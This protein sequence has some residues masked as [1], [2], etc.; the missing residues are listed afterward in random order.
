MKN[1]I[2]NKWA[3][4][5]LTFSGLAALPLTLSAAITENTGTNITINAGSGTAKNSV[6][7]NNN[8]VAA[9]RPIYVSGSGWFTGTDITVSGTAATG[10]GRNG[11][12]IETGGTVSLTDSA[13]TT[14]LYGVTASGTS[15]AILN[16]V[17]VST[18]VTSGHGINLATSSALTMIGGAITT[19]ATG[20]TGINLS[21]ASIGTLSNVNITTQNGTGIN[22]NTSA[23][24]TVTSCTLTSIASVGMLLSNASSLI[25]T[26]LTIRSYSRGLTARS[27]ATA[28]LTGVNILTESINGWA[29][30]S[31]NTGVITVSGGTI[32][33][34][35]VDGRGLAAAGGGTIYASDLV[36]ETIGN[37]ANGLDLGYDYALPG[38]RI[39]GD[40]LTVT[41]S[42]ADAH[43]VNFTTSGTVELMNSSLIV[44]GE[45]N[46]GVNMG[47]VNSNT[48]DYR[49]E[50]H[51]GSVES[52]QGGGIAI[53]VFLPR[54]DGV[55]GAAADIAAGGIYEVL[56]DSGA[57]VTGAAALAVGSI[58]T[59]TDAGGDLVDVDKLTVATVTV[60]GS[61]TLTGD[62][63]IRDTA[64]VVLTMS[65]RSTLTGDLTTSGAA[66]LNMTL[67]H[68]T[69]TGLSTVSD[70]GII[71]LSLTNDSTWKLTGKSKLTTL[72]GANGA[73]ITI[74]N[75]EGGDLTV[76]GGISG[77]AALNLTLGNGVK[78]QKEIHVIVDES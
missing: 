68:S 52:A 34:L 61:S 9:T 43:G 35:G 46:H 40:N 71:N 32:R 77:Q 76:S 13:I 41:V 5:L 27:G 64:A 49:V 18:N 33:T 50:I 38:G 31:E 26:D 66:T 20:A 53:N 44:S 70:S 57:T 60:S 78:G 17:T 75:V 28:N 67:N 62:V 16:N 39:F 36:I 11:V 19:D 30:R 8:G 42:G 72:R 74:A 25:A 3:A 37:G 73:L 6:T 14:T 12:T 7:Y 65:N 10:N 54:A 4:W 1:N 23:S 63:N 58:F 21:G 59:G 47:R 48:G 56:I 22:L 24:A 29:L 51:G 2:I 45:N 55:Y 15:T 69:L